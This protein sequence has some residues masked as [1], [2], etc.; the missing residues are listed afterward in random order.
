MDLKNIGANI[1]G[2]ALGKM[3][4]GENGNSADMLKQVTGMLQ[5]VDLGQAVSKITEVSK[6]SGTDTS[7]L[8]GF[9]TALQGWQ[10]DKSEGAENRLVDLTSK[11]KM[12]D[13]LNTVNSLKDHLPSS[14]T[15]VL[16]TVLPM[17]SNLKK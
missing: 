1:L 5:G 3:L 4:G 2:N 7:N 9:I 8:L 13:I 15:T 16:N 6:S 11:F 10:G 14:I 17:L 12:G